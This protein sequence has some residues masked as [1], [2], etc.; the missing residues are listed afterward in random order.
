MR[1]EVIYNAAT[2]AT[3][4]LKVIDYDAYGNKVS[5]TNPSVKSRFGY[6][7]REFDVETGLQLQPGALLRSGNGPLGQPRPERVSPQAM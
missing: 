7:G 3:S 2:D 4:T 6:P 1:A 5:D